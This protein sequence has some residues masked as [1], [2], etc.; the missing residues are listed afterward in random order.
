MTP[1]EAA[2]VLG[3]ERGA[4]WEDVRVAYREQIRRHH[5]DRAGRSS[6]DRAASITVA[7]RVLAAER[8]DGGPPPSATPPPPAGA[9]RP[10]P[11]WRIDPDPS[12][13]PAVARVDHDALLVRAPAD[14]T[15][16]WLLEAA[17]DVGEV[18][19]VDRSMP[20]AEVLCRFEDEP[21]TS[22]VLTLQGRGADT[23]VFCTVESIEARPAP[24]T[25][26][27][28]DL[29]ELALHRRRAA[30]G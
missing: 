19:Y 29:L 27:V 25:A 6:S 2:A 4:P 11:V 28:V 30:R 16:R 24:P 12:G 26:A 23:E 8:R 22:L 9:S 7:F 17:H 15:F 20:I 21:A 5:P 3:V 14:E 1:A 10:R 13:A 18:T